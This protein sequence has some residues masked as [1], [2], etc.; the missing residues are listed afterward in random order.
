MELLKPFPEAHW[1]LGSVLEMDCS[2]SIAFVDHT[3]KILNAMCDYSVDNG[4]TPYQVWLCTSKGEKVV[5]VPWFLL[6]AMS[7]VWRGMSQHQCA[8]TQAD[9]KIVLYKCD[10][11]DTVRALRDFLCVGYPRE[12]YLR[13]DA[14]ALYRLA[15]YYGITG[16]REWL[17]SRSI[18]TRV[19]VLFMALRTAKCEDDEPESAEK[20]TKACI[21][22]LCDRTTFAQTCSQDC[23][24]GVDYGTMES[25]IDSLKRSPGNESAAATRY[26]NAAF[27]L[28]DKWYGANVPYLRDAHALACQLFGNID[29]GRLE[30]DFIQSVV[31]PST[32]LPPGVPAEFTV[33]CTTKPTNRVVEI[34]GMGPFSS[35]KELCE[36]VEEIVKYGPF[37]IRLVVNNMKINDKDPLIVHEVWKPEATVS[38]YH[39]LAA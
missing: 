37:Q 38:I 19:D 29:V 10:E 32:L 39:R 7:D 9:G 11:P 30:P 31:K 16:V 34:T 20:I 4:N 33:R 18:R 26:Y 12:T 3:F 5:E 28:L 15:T 8:E 14:W 21:Q 24:I 25:I 13:A 6:I 35:G 17:L 1:P 23:L 22:V 2:P 36:R 27:R